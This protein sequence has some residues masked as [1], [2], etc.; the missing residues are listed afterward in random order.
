MEI[1]ESQCKI[2]GKIFDSQAS[3]KSHKGWH[4]RYQRKFETQIRKRLRKLRRKSISRNT[5]TQSK[6]TK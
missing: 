6:T 3:M 5:T 1:M 4:K 2:C